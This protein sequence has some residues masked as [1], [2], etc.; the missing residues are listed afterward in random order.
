VEICSGQSTPSE[1]VAVEHVSNEQPQGELAKSGASDTGL[2]L[3]GGVFLLLA[4]AALRFV[5]RFARRNH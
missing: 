2:L 3:G 1:Q 4:G 5:P